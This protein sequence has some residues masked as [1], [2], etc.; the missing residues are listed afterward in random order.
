MSR[1]LKPGERVRVT[2]ANAM[3]DYQRGDSGTVLQGPFPSAMGGQY[4]IVQMDKDPANLQVT[5]LMEEI[6]VA[7]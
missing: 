2:S 6:E 4:Y 3:P 1:E 5:F 7:D